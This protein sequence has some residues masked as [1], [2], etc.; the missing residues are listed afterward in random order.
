MPYIYLG[1]ASIYPLQQNIKLE[2]LK[3]ITKLEELKKPLFFHIGP[4]GS[5][6]RVTPSLHIPS[7]ACQYTQKD[8]WY[9][10]QQ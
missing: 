1:T 5:D 4:T 3:Q 7:K 8:S 6:R 10:Q 9:K 2:E